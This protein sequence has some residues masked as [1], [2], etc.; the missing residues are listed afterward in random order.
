MVRKIL[1][2]SDQNPENPI[3]RHGDEFDL[4]SIGNFKL[5]FYVRANETKID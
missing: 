3:K 2:K 1:E 4:L 5:I